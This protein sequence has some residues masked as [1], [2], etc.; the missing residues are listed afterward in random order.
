MQGW[1]TI[2]EFYYSICFFKLILKLWLYCREKIPFL[3]LFCFW[4]RFSS[5]LLLIRCNFMKNYF[6]PKQHSKSQKNIW[7]FKLLTLDSLE[8]NQ[9]KIKT[10][11]QS[12]RRHF[13]TNVIKN[14]FRKTLCEKTKIHYLSFN[15]FITSLQY[16][17]LDIN[18]ILQTFPNN[19]CIRTIF[20]SN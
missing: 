9:N 16:A 13:V 10:L 11:S 14:I 4:S 1:S 7:E 2:L 5:S 3:L 19:L 17:F 15:I 8:F 6:C 12:L 20:K 18:D